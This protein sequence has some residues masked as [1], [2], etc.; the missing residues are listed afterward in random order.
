M[1][2]LKCNKEHD[3]SFGSGKYCS[4]QCANS[5]VRTEESKKK[6]SN[7]MKGYHYGGALKRVLKIKKICPVCNKEFEV[8][9]FYK[10]KIYCS[11]ECY[12]KDSEGKFR[13]LAGGGFQINSTIYL[14]QK[15]II[16]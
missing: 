2:C 5:R 4:R 15:N 12:C 10:N 14:F 8:I 13:V 7:T 9:K 3:G 16:Q 6:T 11:R 1:K